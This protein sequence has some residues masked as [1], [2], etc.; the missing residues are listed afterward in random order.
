MK[1]AFVFVLVGFGTKAGL[2]PMHA[3]LPDAHSEAPSPV[4]ALLSGVLLKCALLVIIRYYAITVRAIGP[5]FPQLLLMLL[6]IAFDR[7]R[8]AAVL[9]PAGSQA[10]ARLFQPSS[11]S[12]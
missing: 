6:G 12:A 5:A 7:R 4:S 9:R 8:R 10:E 2:F 11:I 3:W 1:L